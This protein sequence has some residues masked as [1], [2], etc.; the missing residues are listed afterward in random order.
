M[1]PLERR[2][3]QL[4]ERIGARTF[5]IA[6]GVD[7]PSEDAIAAAGIRP[8]ARDLVVVLQRF[9]GAPADRLVSTV[10]R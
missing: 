8:Q 4:E 7:E 6:A 9:G 2:I 5:V 10:R 1:S 3:A